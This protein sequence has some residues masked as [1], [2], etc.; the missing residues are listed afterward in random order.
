[1]RRPWIPSIDPNGHEAACRVSETS[2]GAPVV[3]EFSINEH[4]RG[5]AGVTPHGLEWD[6]P[7]ARVI[8][9]PLNQPQTGEDVPA[10]FCAIPRW[11]RALAKRAC[12]LSEADHEA[13]LS[14]YRRV[15]VGPGQQD[16]V[17]TGKVE[18][19]VGNVGR[20]ISITEPS[21][22]AARAIAKFW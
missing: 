14:I 1:M 12:S 9:S 13:V 11:G 8:P 20:M 15:G 16:P 17:Q 6:C 2:T 22:Y 4:D 19:F 21:R 3:R 7:A 5:H 10:L 18:N